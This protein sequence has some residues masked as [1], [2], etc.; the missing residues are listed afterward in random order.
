[1][2]K[3]TDW[4]FDLTMFD[5][6]SPGG[7]GSAGAGGD[8]AA[9]EG[10]N[11]G[12]TESPASNNPQQ[13]Q[14]P[15]ANVIFGKQAKGEEQ[16]AAAGEQPAEPTEEEWKAVQERFRDFINRDKSATVQGRLK[17]SKQAEADLAKLAPVLQDLAKKY[18]KDAADIDG[19]LA[20]RANDDSLYEEDAAREGVSVEVYK[21]LKQFRDEKAAREE[22]EQRSAY[23]THIRGLIESFDRDVKS[24]FPNADLRTEMQNPMFQRWTSPEFGMSVKDAYYAIHREEIETMAMQVAAQKTQQKLSQSVQSGTRR[25]SENGMRSAAPVRE[26]RSDPSKW[27][28]AEMDEVARRVMRGERIEL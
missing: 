28:S 17:N 24:V 21:Q 3:N 25:P 8:G 16:T 23:E 4:K 1:M 5:A 15:F 13:K 26:V 6:G 2:Q 22:Q 18:G 20:A 10:T 27:S 9:S 12:V 14:D 11:A 7:N 19:I